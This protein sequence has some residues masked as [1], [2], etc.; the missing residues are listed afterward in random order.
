[1]FS[2]SGKRL[3]SQR[4]GRMRGEDDDAY[5][6]GETVLFD[7]AQRVEP[8]LARQRPVDDDGAGVLVADER[9]QTLRARPLDDVPTG[10][11]QRLRVELAD[12]CVILDE[13]DGA[14]HF[15][16]C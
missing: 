13:Y 12:R 16:A 3:V 9:E 1:M 6:T 10:M 11:A 4:R 14:R 5:V 2:L 15:H 7:R 8:A